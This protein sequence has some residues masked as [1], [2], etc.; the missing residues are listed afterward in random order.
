MDLGPLAGF[1]TGSIDLVFRDPQGAWWVAD[2]KSN[3]LDPHRTGRTVLPQF[4]QTHMAYELERHHYYL[5][6]VLYL[7]ALHRWL[8][9]R[10]GP[11]NYIP[12]RHLGGA[13]YLFVRGMVGP[14][15]PVE[16][17]LRNGVAIFRP[18]LPLLDQLNAMF[19]DPAR[20][21]AAR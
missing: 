17:G 14:A 13:A 10:L 19:D 5:Q 15:T 7:L 1:L 12:E 3:R 8:T 2:Y 4:A 11:E 21:Q 9:V 6:G 16:N 18:T 20:A